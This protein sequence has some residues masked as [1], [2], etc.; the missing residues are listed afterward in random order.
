MLGYVDEVWWSRLAQPNMHAWSFDTPLRLIEQQAD[1]KDQEP[2]A[3]ACYGVWF[4]DEENMLI[5][6]ADSRPLSSVT[7]R[8]LDWVCQS[9]EQKGKRVWALVWDNASGRHSA[10]HISQQV[11]EWID[12][13]NEGVK[14]AGG[15]RIITCL[16]PVKSPWLNPI[17]PKWLHGKRAVVEPDGKSS[18]TELMERV[19]Q[20]Y[21]CTKSEPLAQ[22]TS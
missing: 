18:K 17:E 1:K 11:R 14:Q 7:C 2:K 5:R 13:H 6:F 3:L 12:Q 10:W 16:L 15:V 9:L 20:H 19:Y 8:F 21:G 22:K 4:P